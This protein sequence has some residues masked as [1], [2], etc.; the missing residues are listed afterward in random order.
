M[1]VDITGTMGSPYPAPPT[2]TLL[3]HCPRRASLACA[4]HAPDV[5]LWDLARA[6]R[7]ASIPTGT[8]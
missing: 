7:H 5:A 6:L 4:G 1:V 8:Y 2:A 3:A